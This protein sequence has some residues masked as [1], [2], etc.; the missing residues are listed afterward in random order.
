[1]DITLYELTQKAIVTE[2]PIPELY[3]KAQETLTD[4]GL[5]FVTSIPP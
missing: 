3:R 4:K 1:M 2:A 5:N